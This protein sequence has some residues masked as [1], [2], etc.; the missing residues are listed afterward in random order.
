LG[1][2]KKATTKHKKSKIKNI[3][4]QKFIKRKLRTYFSRENSRSCGSSK[5]PPYFSE[6]ER[7]LKHTFVLYAPVLW[8]IQDFSKGAP[9]WFIAVKYFYSFN[10]MLLFYIFFDV[11][12]GFRA[13][14]PIEPWIHHCVSSE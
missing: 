6:D 3:Y 12:G 14:E 4:I 2:K 1:W 5:S 9:Y 10:L 13:V 8:R 7:I 11:Q